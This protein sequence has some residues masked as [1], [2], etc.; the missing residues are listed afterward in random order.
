MPISGS[1]AFRTE[2]AAALLLLGTLTCCA[3][4]QEAVLQATAATENPRRLCVGDHT[5]ELAVGDLKRTAIVHV[6]A[7]YDPAKP[8]PV[9]LALHGA[10]MNGAAMISFCGLNETAEK[11]SFVVVYP[12][13]TG[14][15]PLLTWNAG[16]F[17]KGLGSQVDDVA[18]LG[19]LLDEIERLINVDVKRVYACGMSNGGMMCY[20]LAAELS[21]RIAAIAPVAGTMAIGEAQPHRPVSVI[22]FHGTLDTL[23]PYDMGTSNTPFWLRLKSV[24][25]SVQTWAK[26][27]G[28]DEQH[29]VTDLL[30]KD[31]DELKVT[32]QTY[33][34]GSAGTSV[35]LVTIDGGGHTWP[36]QVPPVRF[37]GK[38]AMNISANDL[39]WTFFEQ[40]PLP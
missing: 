2:W 32:R 27:D 12:S 33:G 14:P 36:G 35:V 17:T 26:L 8:M 13:G 28:C 38:S 20:R 40:H 11:R 34:P 29:P 22:H 9:V 16:G 10:A 3:S 23:V 25:T 39:I 18:F 37:L 5:L 7:S 6:P 30:S 31:G 24:E 4:G 19:Q 21:D 15:G 1:Q